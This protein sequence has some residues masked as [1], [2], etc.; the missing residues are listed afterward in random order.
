MK[1]FRKHI[2]EN[3]II[4]VL[5]IPP[6]SYMMIS[7]FFSQLAFNM[8]HFILI[9]VIYKLTHSNTAVSG[10]ILSLTIPSIVF[11][12]FSGV[13]V[14]RWNKKKVLFF[15]NL[16]RGFIILPFLIYNLH[17]G[18]IYFLTFLIAIATQFFIPAESSII[19]SLVPRRLIFPANAVFSL[20]IYGT[21]LF[22]YILAGPML[23][24][25][26]RENSILLLSLFFF[27]LD[28]Y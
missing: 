20:G 19:P 18:I 4:S 16:L 21:I 3:E 24:A 7:E 15:S 26:G 5:K 8:Q 14:D 1:F 12:L 28:N 10:L 25:L 9:V 13:L 27:L 6:F 2:V 17:I 11:S 22:G 23:L